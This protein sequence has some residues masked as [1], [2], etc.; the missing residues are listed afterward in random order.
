[1]ELNK[2]IFDT[3]NWWLAIV[4]VHWFGFIVVIACGMLMRLI[5][6]MFTLWIQRRKKDNVDRLFSK[7]AQNGKNS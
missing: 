4:Y 6:D 7:I 5:W 2:I 1:M 3:L